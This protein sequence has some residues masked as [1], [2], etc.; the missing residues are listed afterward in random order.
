MRALTGFFYELRSVA[1]SVVDD[2]LKKYEKEK[3]LRQS[4]K[5]MIARGLIEYKAGIYKPSKKGLIFFQRNQPE[6]VSRR[7]MNIKQWDGKWRLISFDVPLDCNRERTL[8]R[9]L[10][11]QFDFYR[12][13]KS[14]WVCPNQMSQNFWK[15]VVD[16]ELDKY[17][18]AMLV[19]IIEGD[20]ELKNY[21]FSK[22]H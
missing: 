22:H 13:H 5:R 12:L 20:E 18:K 9:S 16:Y 1:E 4:L 2:F 14:V 21:F 6:I 19:E 15:L 10:L 7:D 3:Y 11:K 8:L 17:C